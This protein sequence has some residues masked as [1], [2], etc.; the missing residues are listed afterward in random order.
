MIRKGRK[1]PPSADAGSERPRRRR[2]RKE[3]LDVQLTVSFRFGDEPGDQVTMIDQRSVPMVG[4]IVA[5]RD[6]VIRG[7]VGLLMRVAV[8]QPRIAG[9]LFPIGKLL[10]RRKK[11]K[12]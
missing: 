6:R 11:S 10:P 8:T 1:Q 7:F 2:G 9:Q 3:P 12:K 5:N 4:S